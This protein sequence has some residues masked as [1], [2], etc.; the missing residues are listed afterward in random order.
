M[1]TAEADNE[2]LVRSYV[3]AVTKHDWVTVTDLLAEDVV[4]HGIGESTRGPQAIIEEYRTII[5]AFPDLTGTI[6]DVLRRTTGLRV[7]S[8]PGEHT[9]VCFRASTQRTR[10]SR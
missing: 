1:A 9:K 6:E 5:D 7:Q 10:L 3:A 2:E 8:Q 4:R